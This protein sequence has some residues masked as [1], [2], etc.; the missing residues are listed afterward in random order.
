MRM[1]RSGATCQYRSQ[2]SMVSDETTLGA[3][4]RKRAEPIEHDLKAAIELLN[5]HHRSFHAARLFAERTGHS[6]PSDTRS[7]SEILIGLLT[8]LSGRAR[9]KGSD[10]SDGSDVKAANV[11]CAIDTPR[12]NGC[13]PA[14][15]S[16]VASMRADDVTAFDD[17]PYLFLV[18]WD[19][20]GPNRVPR[21]RVWCVRPQH[22][23]EFRRI[24]TTWYSLRRTGA[25]TSTNFQ[26]HPPRNL[27]TSLI[28][29]TCG[30]L[31]YPL[32]FTAEFNGTT[33]EPV[34]F[35][36]EVLV[37]GGCTLP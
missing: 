25:I 2:E 14:G 4:A 6:V 32:L 5:E 24:V 34:S 21:C 15:R 17:V 11:W 23:P 7:Y 37:A 16:S 36:P 12:F 13:A 8:G 18:L 3:N 35:E 26:L 20:R 22:D 27:D 30:N 19:E 28:R 29:N 1:N 9:K 33:F 10:L 31:L